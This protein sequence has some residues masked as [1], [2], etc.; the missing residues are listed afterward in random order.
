MIGT[1]S[2]MQTIENNYLNNFVWTKNSVWICV[3]APRDRCKQEDDEI[4]KLVASTKVRRT[5]WNSINESIQRL[6]RVNL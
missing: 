6:S 5:V 1:F 3:V 2:K 4:E